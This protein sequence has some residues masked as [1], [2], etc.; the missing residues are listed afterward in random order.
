MNRFI[1][2]LLWLGCGLIYVV[3]FIW[4]FV[5]ILAGSGRAWKMIVASDRLLNAATGGKDTETMSSRSARGRDE[6]ISSWCLLC[7][8]LDA[9]NENHCNNSRGI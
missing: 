7:K 9:I 1:L 8:F 3:S 2:L 6:G 4:C 5:A